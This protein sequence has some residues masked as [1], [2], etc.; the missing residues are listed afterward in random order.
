MVGFSQDVAV[1]L[2]TRGRAAPWHKVPIDSRIEDAGP[3]TL[4]YLHAMALLDYFQE[5]SGVAGAIATKL[6]ALK[7]RAL[8]AIVDD[9]A[10]HLY[11]PVIDNSVAHPYFAAIRADVLADIAAVDQLRRSLLARGTKQGN[12]LAQLPALRL[13][14]IV[15]GNGGNSPAN[16][17]RAAVRGDP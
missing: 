7:H 11:T 15:A 1:E 17:Q 10:R 8:Y 6:L 12:R 2:E 9:R 14:D 3:K 5:T 13:R 16:H 4:L